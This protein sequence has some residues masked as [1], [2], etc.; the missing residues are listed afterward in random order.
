MENEDRLILDF[1][2]QFDLFFN[3]GYFHN[4]L[5]GQEKET[6]NW[7]EI[8]STLLRN[9]LIKRAD[10]QK[11]PDNFVNFLKSTPKV[12]DCI[13]YLA[14]HQLKIMKEKLSDG[15]SINFGLML[16]AFESFSQGLLY[17]D[18]VDERTKTFRR[19]EDDRIHMMDTVDYGYPRWHV[20]CRAATF[21]GHD[22]TT[23]HRIDGYVGLS[24]AI[25]KKLSPKQS[26][27]NGERPSPPNEGNP[28][29]VAE[30]LPYFTSASFDQLDDYFDTPAVRSIL[31]L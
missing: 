16:K 27:P 14:E 31:H 22:E 11:Y 10:R 12:K 3:P 26:G 8:E 6:M 25:Q 18:V 4:P 23:W 30:K 17:D 20:F 15:I 9:W 21:L 24:H 13:D 29:L 5:E 7:Y 1:W 28:Q 2:Y 19:H